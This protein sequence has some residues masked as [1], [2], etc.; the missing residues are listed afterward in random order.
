MKSLFL[1]LALV[2]SV[3]TAEEVTVT[4][5]GSNYTSALENAKVAALEKGAST[6]IIGESNARDNKVTEKIDQYNG[7]IIKN[8]KVVSNSKTMLGFEVTIVADVVPKDNTVRKQSS[9]PLSVDFEE[10]EKRE[11]IVNRLGN[12]SK[13]IHADVS[14][15]T[16]QVGKYQTTF[17]TKVVLSWQPK[18]ITDVKAFTTVL[19]DKGKTTNNIYDNVSGS[20]INNVVARF[21]L[22][23]ALVGVAMDSAVK[24]KVPENSTN[25]MLCFS[26]YSDASFKCSN[27]NVDL[28]FP[29]TPQL[30]LVAKV[31]GQDVILYKQYLDMKL[32]RFVQAGDSVPTSGFIRTSFK[33]NFH[34]PAVVV[35]EQ[36][37]QTVDLTFIADNSIIKSATSVNVY[38]R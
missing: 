34:N 18:W 30:L 12:V 38:L 16:Y 11:K 35:Y 28:A 4:G 7:G 10:Y 2:A 13:A 8:Y 20:T 33:T 27:L 17:Q 5:Y 32:Y 9:L 3:A 23:G 19:D 37:T 36:E 25:M 26:E 1:S 31:N 15:T 14:N 22:A 29:R 21:G 6:F 24:P